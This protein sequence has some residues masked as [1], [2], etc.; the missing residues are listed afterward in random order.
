[1][2]QSI[3]IVNVMNVSKFI[4]I[5]TGPTQYN[6]M[7]VTSPAS[8]DVWVELAASDSNALVTQSPEW[9]EA[10]CAYGNYVNASRMYEIPG[11]GTYILPMVRSR[12]LPRILGTLA[13][14]PSSWGFGG[15]LGNAP[16]GQQEIKLIFE[17]LLKQREMRI[18][19]R[20]NP[21]LSKA[22]EIAK[23][24]G[25]IV[26]PRLAHVLDL[27]GGFPFIWSHKFRTNTR[28]NIR[29]S[30]ASNLVVECDTTGRLIPVFFQLYEHSVKRWAQ[31]QNEPQWLAKLRAVQRDSIQK[32]SAWAKY[33]GEA[34]RLWIAWYQNEPAAAI[35]V[36]QGAN[37]HYT[38]GVMNQ[39]IAGPTR[40]NDLLHKLAIEDAC[41]AGCRYYHMGETGFS[42]S[43]ARFKG[44]FGAVA[45]PY[46]E[47]RI[48]RLPISKIDKRIRMII[49][50][51]IGFKDV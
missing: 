42:K 28:R 51:I 3:F 14:Y 2:S 48:E 27:E 33:L 46:S 6:H 37:A 40:A 22:W 15:I 21:L 47:F 17:D 44:R 19:I 39:E 24:E 26:T 38:R 11:R 35:I 13:G 49:K 1:M 31:M 7:R 20:P 41:N 43:L 36:L 12:Y 32:F 10:V 30:E 34:F 18:K 45:Y 16:L 4:G 5:K 50:R 8:R 23:I 9:L 25:V 29:K